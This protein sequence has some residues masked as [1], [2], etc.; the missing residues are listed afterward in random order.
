MQ[1]AKFD[2]A[3]AHVIAP[4]SGRRVSLAFN[5]H[6]AFKKLAYA[7]FVFLNELGFK[8]PDRGVAADA[9]A[10]AQCA[11]MGAASHDNRGIVS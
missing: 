10:E 2:G 11:T 8:L 5:L 7:D 9:P 4:F 1:P 3:V 6:R